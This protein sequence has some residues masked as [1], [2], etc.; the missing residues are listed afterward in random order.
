[1]YI[2]SFGARYPVDWRGILS[3]LKVYTV[4]FTGHD[5]LLYAY[6]SELKNNIGIRTMAFVKTVNHF[7]LMIISFSVIV[8]G[9]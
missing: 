8:A 1:V 9:D 2:S 4:D 6:N 5:T 3:D 7:L